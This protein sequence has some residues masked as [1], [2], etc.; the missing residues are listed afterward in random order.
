MLVGGVGVRIYL[1]H[2]VDDF[3]HL[4]FTG[5]T[6]NLSFLTPPAHPPPTLTRVFLR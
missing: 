4:L 3:L 2:G 5:Y 6:L 1:D